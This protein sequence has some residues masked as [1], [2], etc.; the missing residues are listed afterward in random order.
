MRK[1]TRRTWLAAAG[2]TSVAVGLSSRAIAD[3][4]AGRYPRNFKAVPRRHPIQKKNLPNGKLITKA[5]KKFHFYNDLVKD[6]MVAINFIYT[7]CKK[8]CPPIMANL[9]KVQKLLHGRVGRDVFM[10]S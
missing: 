2:M 10:Y 4:T 9:V 8:V 7:N 1:M 3:D 5:G 6:K